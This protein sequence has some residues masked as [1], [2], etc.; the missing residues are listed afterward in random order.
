M[1]FYPINNIYII[2]AVVYFYSLILVPI[3]INPDQLKVIHERS[4]TIE[5]EVGKNCSINVGC[6]ILICSIYK[7]SLSIL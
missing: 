1:F 6:N 7:F 3:N 2:F 4:K 5:L